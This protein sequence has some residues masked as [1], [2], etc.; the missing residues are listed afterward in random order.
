MPKWK[1]ILWAIFKPGWEIIKF[2]DG[3]VL[4]RDDG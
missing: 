2:S 1:M 3:W 4:W